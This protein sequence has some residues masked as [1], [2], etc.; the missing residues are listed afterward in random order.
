[1]VKDG[2]YITSLTSEEALDFRR[3][4]HFAGY[5]FVLDVQ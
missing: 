2:K 1:M 5:F 3:M 4:A